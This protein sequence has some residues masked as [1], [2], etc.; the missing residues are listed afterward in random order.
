QLSSSLCQGYT[1]VCISLITCYGNHH[2]HHV[3]AKDHNLLLCSSSKWAHPYSE[4]SSVDSGMRIGEGKENLTPEGTINLIPGEIKKKK[5]NS[6]PE[7][8]MLD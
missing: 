2:H 4:E 7:T 1:K 3:I 5:Q 8:F 6:F